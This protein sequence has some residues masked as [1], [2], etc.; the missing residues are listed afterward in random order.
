MNY[1][2]SGKTVLIT[3][4]T[5][6]LGRNLIKSFLKYNPRSIIITYRSE[7]EMQLLKSELSAGSLLLQPNNEFPTEIEF[8]QTDITKQDQINN[9]TSG[10]YEKYGQ[11]HILVN[12]VGGYIGGKSI[13]ELKESEWDKMM[14]INLKSAFLISKNILPQM[15]EKRYGKL[16]HVSSRTGIKAEGND[17][18]YAASKA[19]LI[20]FVESVA[21]DVKTYNININCILP[22]IIDTETNRKAMPDADYAKWVKPDDL[23]NVILF[24]CS[25]YSN[26]IN[27][28]S[29]PTYGLL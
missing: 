19:G 14:E 4:G 3:G 1:N 26:T 11:I 8:K 20:R 29:I 9:L 21:Q 23:S 27:G 12:L 10:I 28:A 15:I 24:L 22:T 6:G 17:S 13:T 18:A 7:K 5:G 16:V 25:D 2:L